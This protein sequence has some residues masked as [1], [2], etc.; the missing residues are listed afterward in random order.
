MSESSNIDTILTIV[1]GGAL[2]VEELPLV[3]VYSILGC[4]YPEMKIDCFQ[5]PHSGRQA[6][7]PS[8]QKEEDERSR[9]GHKRS[10]ESPIGPSNRFSILSCPTGPI[11][12]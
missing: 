7:D 3:V 8:T 1:R 9:R 4:E 6:H 11:T 2:E 5:Q 12:V 10:P